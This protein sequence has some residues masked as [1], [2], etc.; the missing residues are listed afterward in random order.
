[1]NKKDLRDFLD[2]KAALYEQ[3]KFIGTDPIQIP[4]QFSKKEDREIAGFLTATI[5]WGN[6]KSIINNATQMM[7]LMEQEPYNFVMHHQQQ[8]LKSLDSFVHRTFNG[9][10]FSTFIRG[11]RAN[12]IQ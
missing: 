8:D 7:Q 12:K 11:L 1:M 3:P 6:R 9:A 4:H 5:A 10:D 2:E